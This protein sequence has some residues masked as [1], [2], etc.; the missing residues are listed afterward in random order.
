MNQFSFF[1]I[2][3]ALQGLAILFDEFYFHH[4]RGL[5]VWERRGHP[6]D[7]LTVLLCFGFLL[8]FSPTE[9]N[10]WIYSALAIFSS[11]FVTKDEAVHAK[12]C[13]VSENWLHAVLYILHP[14]VFIGAGILWY[15]NSAPQILLVQT[16]IVFLFLIYQIGYWNFYAKSDR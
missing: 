12:Y 15:Q 1:A 9:A 6:L 13:T 16:L 11:I 5:P 4:R 8:L 7:T 2:P 3:F 10:V 14:L